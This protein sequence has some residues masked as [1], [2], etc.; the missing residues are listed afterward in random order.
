[1]E[2]GHGRRG[3]RRR[4][5]CCGRLGRRRRC[6]WWFSRVQ[7]RWRRQWRS[8]RVLGAFALH[9]LLRASAGHPALLLHVAAPLLRVRSA[10]T[11]AATLWWLLRQL[12][13]E[14]LAR[15]QRL[16]SAEEVVGRQLSAW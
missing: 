9:P 7:R 14:R 4:R 10:A 2:G 8:E 16:E 1:M 13:N 11:A 6:W 15:G 5:R 12:R 3:G